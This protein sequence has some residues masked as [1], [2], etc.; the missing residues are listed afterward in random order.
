MPKPFRVATPTPSTIHGLLARLLPLWPVEL[1]DNSVA[2]CEKRVALL[3]RALRLERQRGLAG[4]WTYDLSRHAGL[5][6]CYRAE[7]ASLEARK[8]AIGAKSDNA[9]RAT[10]SPGACRAP[11]A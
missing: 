5:L 3:R 8:A 1:A 4:N 7:V 6:A 2:G 9:A 11:S 10:P